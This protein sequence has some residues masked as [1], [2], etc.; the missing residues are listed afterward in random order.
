MNGKRGSGIGWVSRNRGAGI[1]WMNKGRI[2][3]RMDDRKGG[4][5]TGWMSI[6]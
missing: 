3:E 1:G 6:E 4:S 2:R 5:E